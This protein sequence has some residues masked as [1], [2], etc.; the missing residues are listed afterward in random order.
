MRAVYPGDGRHNNE[1]L[2]LYFQYTKSM[3]EK[4]A[5][6]HLS[7]SKQKAGF[8]TYIYI[9]AIYRYMSTS[10]RLNATALAMF[11][12]LHQQRPRPFRNCMG[13]QLAAL[14]QAFTILPLRYIPN[15]W[16]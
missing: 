5:D 12:Q 4:D 6:L 7:V 3:G 10:R 15:C 8:H 9:Q 13:A 2:D 14:Y 1:A 11:D 16:I